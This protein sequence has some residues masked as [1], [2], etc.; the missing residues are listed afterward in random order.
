[1]MDTSKINVTVSLFKHYRTTLERIEKF[2]SPDYFTDVNLYGRLYTKH[3]S[4]TEIYHETLSKFIDETKI[5]I[6]TQ[7]PSFSDTAGLKFDKK[8]NV[9]TSFGPTWSSHWFKVVIDIPKDCLGK[10]VHFRWNS[11]CE[12][13]IWSPDGKPLQ[14]LNGDLDYLSS[15][16]GDH[17]FRDSRAHYI[18]SR[19]LTESELHVTYFVEMACNTLFG[20]GN[21]MITPPNPNRY[22]TLELVEIAVFDRD[23][24]SQRGYQALYTANSIINGIN[25]EKRETIKAVREI[26]NRFFN[27]KNGDS[28]LDIIA[29]GNCHIDSA[30]L[31]PYGETMRK[32]A[33][34]W[35]STI[36]L[37]ERP[38]LNMVFV[39]SQAQQLDWMKK[40]YPTLF[41]EIK[42][43]INQKKF[44]PVGGT[45]VEMDGN[46]PSGES[47]IR[48]F[49]YGQK[50]FFEEFGIV[51]KE[52]WLP[53]TFGYSAQLPQIMKLCGI[54]YFVSQKMS[55]S[56][57]NKFPHHIFLWEGIDGT[58][59]IAHFPPGDTYTSS[60]KVEEVLKTGDNLSDKG[61]VS[62]ALL[63]YGHGDGGG[64]PDEHML[65]RIKRLSNV[66]GCPKVSVGTVENF[67]SRIEESRKNLN[68]WSGELYLEL[69]NG[70][71]TTQAEMK[72]LNRKCEFLLQRLEFLST[73]FALEKGFSSELSILI[74]EI[75]DAW[76][77]VLLNQFHDVLPGS[78]IKLVHDEAEEIFR[79]TMKKIEKLSDRITDRLLLEDLTESAGNCVVFNP[80]SFERVEIQSKLSDRSSVS[81]DQV[82]TVKIPPMGYLSLT[83]AE[84]S[85]V[86]LP[87]WKMSSDATFTIENQYLK[88]TVDNLGRVT[89]LIHLSGGQEVIEFGKY[90][91][92]FIIYDDI[93]L[94]WDAWDVMDYHLE[95]AKPVEEFTKTAVIDDKA[96]NVLRVQLK[97]GDS[98]FITMG[99]QLQPH[100]PYLE[101]VI[102][103]DWKERH[104]F[105]KVQFP[106]NVNASTATFDIQ[107]GHLQRPTHFNTSWEWAK[108]EVCGHKWMDLSEYNWGVAILNDSKYGHAV[109]RNVMRLSLLRS[110]KAPDDKADERIHEIEYAIFPHKGSFQDAGVIK[111]SYIFNTR[112]VIHDDKTLPKSWPVKCGSFY[113]V[114]HPGIVIETVKLATFIDGAIIARLYESFGG[115]CTAMF[116]TL[117]QFKTVVECN[118]LEKEVGE[119]IPWS[120]NGIHLMFKPFEVKT[121]LLE[122]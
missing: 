115:R 17:L 98:S 95:T 80:L 108:Y 44:C 43:W 42:H 70:T 101:V 78:S 102:S 40:L 57:V 60:V 11:G 71:Y 27:Q 91:N 7:R 21:G 107:F 109:H 59:V 6:K 119:V 4:Q 38:D 46:I 41:D 87:K 77:K 2:I 30:W 67:F 14:G 1:M 97:V 16:S 56:L 54:E 29:L 88:A 3:Y 31:W 26:A 73:I 23:K 94:Y 12:A 49:L 84:I 65:Q 47:F 36:R 120:R 19:N 114:D 58:E 61:R 15:G 105:L 52:F 121:L 25:F 75:E 8:A 85:V 32:C 35:S 13:L 112:T 18:I 86:Q 68:R 63:L 116:K 76:K 66:D 45:W 20:A 5:L 53:D 122:V 28:Q 106:V 55:W 104:K 39:C 50:F 118:G 64:G 117:K 34:S 79:D 99:I 51:C 74:A 110:P 37:L 24:S 103:V 83:D 92:E 96:P 111:E 69:H 113:T 90:G 48:Q 82:A 9:G 89:S 72:R 62:T 33:R 93:P 81:K 100:R 10:E 22:F